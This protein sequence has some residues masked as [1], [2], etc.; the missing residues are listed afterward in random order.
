MF[1]QLMSAVQRLQ[2][3]DKMN[4]QFHRAKPTWLS[5]QQGQG[6]PSG[7]AAAPAPVP[8]SQPPTTPPLNSGLGMTPPPGAGPQADMPPAPVASPDDTAA[9]QMLNQRMQ[10]MT[11]AI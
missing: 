1:H 8:P 10:M 11:G 6:Q 5:G 4:L 2:P 9:R 3:G 7:Q